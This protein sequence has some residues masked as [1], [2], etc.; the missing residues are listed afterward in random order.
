MGSSDRM[1]VCVYG[2]KLWGKA[3]S[4][5]LTYV[6]LIMI[7]QCGGCWSSSSSLAVGLAMTDP[8]Q[9]PLCQSLPGTVHVWLGP[10][11]ADRH[12]AIP[13]TRVELSRQAFLFLDQ[14]GWL[15]MGHLSLSPSLSSSLL[16][17]L[18]HTWLSTADQPFAPSDTGQ[19]N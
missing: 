4:Y 5:K 6:F 2:R 18:P 8:W 16:F 9:V 1:M 12:K 14:Q 11:T 17:L 15:T 19:C 7:G 10:S 13:Y 3:A